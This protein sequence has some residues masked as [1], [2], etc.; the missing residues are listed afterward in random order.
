MLVRPFLVTLVVATLAT[1]AALAWSAK[2]Q[3]EPDTTPDQEDGYMWLDADLTRGAR[4]NRV[5]FNAFTVQNTGYGLHGITTNPNSGAAQTAHPNWPGQLAALLGVWKDCNGDGFVGLGDNALFEY[6][7][8][9]LLGKTDVCPVSDPGPV[10]TGSFGSE[11]ARQSHYYPV[12]HNDGVWVREFIPLGPSGT[13]AASRDANPFDLQDNGA[14]VWADWGVPGA[15]PPGTRCSVVFVPEG[16]YSSTG[17][18][19]EYVD[20]LDSFF[21]TDTWNDGVALVGGDDLGAGQ[22]SFRDQPR[23]QE[24]SAS[25][26]NRANPWGRP[27][28]S[29]AVTAFDCSSGQLAHQKAPA[30]AHEFGVPRPG[31]L[32]TVNPSGSIAGTLNETGTAF[33]DCDRSDNKGEWEH[34]AAAAPYGLE[35]PGIVNQVGDKIES[36]FPMSYSEGQRPVLAQTAALGRAAP[37]DGGLRAW[38]SEG[39][40]ISGTRI[41]EDRNPYASRAN[42]RGSATEPIIHTTAYAFVSPQAVSDHRITLNSGGITGAYGAESCQGTSSGSRNG[43][44]CDPNAWTSPC[45]AHYTCIGPVAGQSIDVSVKVGQ[46]Y[47]L[48]DV[49]CYDHSAGPLRAEGISWGTLSGTACA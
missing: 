43:W 36:D 32:P 23:D 2:G 25:N 20:C 14:R 10:P 31:G 46:A 38:D 29:A 44:N 35:D 12:T 49:D 15:L 34:Q 6:R 8:E 48:R 9:L 42:V 40:W 16:T 33:D 22:M 28:D 13:A 41:A 5:Y 45:A 21:V 11:G 1:P 3:S 47:Q 30:V 26:L 19:L 37:K 27:G 24:R 17:G 18:F 39:H 7:S 4:G